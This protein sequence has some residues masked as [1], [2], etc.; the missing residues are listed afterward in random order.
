MNIFR[1]FKKDK[2]QKDFEFLNLVR[3]NPNKV[4]FKI[5]SLFELPLLIHGINTDSTL[6]EILEDISKYIDRNTYMR[7]PVQFGQFFH[8]NNELYFV[9][10]FNLYDIDFDRLDFYCIPEYKKLYNEIKK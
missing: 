5:F 10:K 7:R 3:N 8:R 4:I 6:E 1:V 9:F 2:D